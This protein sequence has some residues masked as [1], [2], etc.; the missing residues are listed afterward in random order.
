MKTSRSNRKFSN[1]T[2][3]MALA[4]SLGLV[5]QN[6][7]NAAFMRNFFIP[8]SSQQGETEKPTAPAEAVPAATEPAAEVGASGASTD[9][10]KADADAAENNRAALENALFSDEDAAEREPAE[11][12]SAVKPTEEKKTEVAPESKDAASEEKPEVV[13]EKKADEAKK[14]YLHEMIS[15]ELELQAALSQFDSSDL[16]DAKLAI[17]FKKIIDGLKDK[18]KSVLFNKNGKGKI[19][20][21]MTENGVSYEKPSSTKNFCE[22][23]LNLQSKNIKRATWVTKFSLSSLASKADA[24]ALESFNDFSKSG[25]FIGQVDMMTTAIS[26]VPSLTSS[27][28]ATKFYQN[29]AVEDGHKDQAI[30]PSKFSCE[31]EGDLTLA[32]LGALTSHIVKVSPMVDSVESLDE[33]NSDVATTTAAPKLPVA[34]V[35]ADNVIVPMSEGP[36]AT[37]EFLKMI[38]APS[39]EPAPAP[40]VET[41]PAPP[42]PDAEAASSGI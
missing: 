12:E 10:A 36:E 6:R 30:V 38:G 9:T 28:P 7:A 39:T 2:P 8:A 5:M 24:S 19:K 20:I 35:L 41:P 3:F 32:N 29:L 1:L 42:A 16:K 23:E 21:Y 34:P 14:Q 26:L 37:A 40:E 18:N 31:M 4:L 13:A 27:S 17:D 25:V 33:E 22:L 11:D 15:D